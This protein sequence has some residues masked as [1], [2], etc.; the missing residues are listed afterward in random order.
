MELNILVTIPAGPVFDTFFD[1]EQISELTKL[2]TVEW[3]KKGAQ[4]TKEELCRYIKGKDIC[5][6]G[7]GSPV[8]DGEVLN[9]ADCLK[10]I[11]HT[12]GS[13]KPYITDS[14]YE[15]GIRVVS[16]NQVFA[17][18]VAESVVAY[19]LASL[20]EIPH[21]ST[22]LKEGDWPAQ[23]YNR[24]LLDRSVGI[25][26][27][28]MIAKYV[29]G[30]LKPFHNSIKVFSRHI[31]QEELDRFQMKKAGLE[32]IFS[33][34]DIISIHSGMTPENHHLI[35]EELLRK[36][37]KGALL[38]NTARGAI[39]DE[40]ALCRVLQE[41]EIYAVLDVFETEPLPADHELTK[42][43]RAIL[44]PHMGGPTID[45]R[46]AVTKS[47]IGDIRS[48]LVGGALNCEIDRNYAQKMSAY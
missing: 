23:F 4:Y 31:G 38:I 30:M 48:F 22:R 34:C 39:I 44:M 47:V 12:G 3:N 45:R 18:S 5:V 40:A 27:Y 33:T 42:C 32:E 25:V 41:K 16:G 8:F 11:A 36:M 28:G 20:R 13:V 1:E 26:G 2:G 10:L 9:C 24:G 21:Y 6:T 7:W 19:A 35:T 43:Q 46:L 29:V 17:E 14:V 15:R 37:K